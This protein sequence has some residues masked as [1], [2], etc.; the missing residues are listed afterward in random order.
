MVGSTQQHCLCTAK[1]ETA[2]QQGSSSTCGECNRHC[3]QGNAEA[4]AT[5][6]ECDARAAE[7]LAPSCA[8]NTCCS[9]MNRA[10][11]PSQQQKQTA[12]KGAPEAGS[13]GATGQRQRLPPD[14]D[15][16]SY[17]DQRNTKADV[18]AANP[19][20]CHA[21]ATE[22][23]ALVVCFYSC[24]TLGQIH[25]SV[26]AMVVFATSSATAVK[27]TAADAAVIVML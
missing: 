6:A 15:Q 20:E 23:L 19:A 25:P 17:C 27:V 18:I 9:Y 2:A 13:A 24:C 26:A 5:P 8:Q 21:Q 12:Q 14:Y 22:Q 3:D 4:G 7:Q 1:A 11:L 10:V 16:R